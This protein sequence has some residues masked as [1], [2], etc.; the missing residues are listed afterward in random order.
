MSDFFSTIT[1]LAF[2]E[3]FQIQPL[4]SSAQTPSVLQAQP[5]P[6]DSARPPLWD[7]AISEL[8]AEASLDDTEFELSNV[9]AS[10][11]YAKKAKSAQPER[12]DPSL[13]SPPRDER[14]AFRLR[15]SLPAADTP[16]GVMAP[17]EEVSEPVEMLASSPNVD[18][19][20]APVQLV[21]S[22]KKSGTA[23]TKQAIASLHVDK[24]QSR[25]ESAQT[26]PMDDHE[27]SEDIPMKLLAKSTVLRQEDDPL[28][29][30][31]QPM[32]S[33]DIGKQKLDRAQSLVQTATNEPESSAVIKEPIERPSM[34]ST[35][36]SSN[37]PQQSEV[38]IVTEEHEIVAVNQ[39]DLPLEQCV[40]SKGDLVTPKELT[41]RYESTHRQARLGAAAASS[42]RSKVSRIDSGSH[43][44]PPLKHKTDHLSEVEKAAYSDVQQVA[45]LKEP[46]VIDSKLLFA[47]SISRPPQ[48][49]KGKP[50]MTRLAL[51]ADQASASLPT[52]P[53]FEEKPLKNKPKVDRST[54]V[55]QGNSSGVSAS[56]SLQAQA[57]SPQASTE[58]VQPTPEPKPIRSAAPQGK[59]E[60]L[61]Q[62]VLAQQSS[63]SKPMSKRMSSMTAHG[64]VTQ[65]EKPDQPNVRISIGTIDIKSP[66]PPLQ[67]S[68][69]AMAPS[70]NALAEYL[71]GRDSGD[72]A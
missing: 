30:L 27:S 2:E 6:D 21:A 60:A 22:S 11:P 46:P 66:P 12:V 3:S 34:Q 67:R 65:S 14:D 26:A 33:F 18:R 36:D 1:A 43:R 42:D 16:S 61:G 45:P 25:L 48:P 20:T 54:I 69:P 72:I 24:P 55:S 7:E 4:I 8:P 23:T 39:Q 49:L 10:P 9:D 40:E 57:K 31:G 37:P 56:P 35:L 32:L 62:Q 47:P 53:R 38:G 17:L 50:Q 59:G 68:Q 41:K 29:L 15:T 70:R 71:R 19:R 5:V 51:D 13:P 58:A 63:V 44:T 52:S 64:P 28:T